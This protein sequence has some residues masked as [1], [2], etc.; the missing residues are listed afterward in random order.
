LYAALACKL[1]YRVRA[2]AEPL[3]VTS[4]QHHFYHHKHE[5]IKRPKIAVIARFYGGVVNNSL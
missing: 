5:V 1:R 4:H 3:R 2:R